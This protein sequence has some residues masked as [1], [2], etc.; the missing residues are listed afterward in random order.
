[1]ASGRK[2]VCGGLGTEWA[3]AQGLRE[4]LADL[5]IALGFYPNIPRTASKAYDEVT[6]AVQAE[7]PRAPILPDTFIERA[8][9]VALRYDFSRPD[10][11]AR[12]GMTSLEASYV[13]VQHGKRNS[14]G[15]PTEETKP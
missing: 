7:R 13:R 10:D 2:C 6:G 8:V 11:D 4:R 3:E 12:V 5:E 9:Q 15:A 1:L 14:G